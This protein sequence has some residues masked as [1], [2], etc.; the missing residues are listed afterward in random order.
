MSKTRQIVL[1]KLLSGEEGE[2]DAPSVLNAIPLGTYEQVVDALSAFNTTP[3]GS[4]S[5]ESF[6]VLY[7]PGLLIQMP[8]VGPKDPVMQA[9][10]SLQEE[11][12]AWTVLARICKRLGWKMMDPGSGRTFG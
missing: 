3:D 8:M 11:D 1:V 7:G 12:I 2:D 4:N 9:A 5:A 6:G 10:V